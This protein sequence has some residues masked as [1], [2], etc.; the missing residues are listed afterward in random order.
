MAALNPFEAF[1][2]TYTPRPVK[3]KRTRRTGGRGKPAKDKRLEE[4]SRLTAQ[5]RARRSAAGCRGAGVA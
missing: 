1:A 5:Y 2:D 4:R 3:A